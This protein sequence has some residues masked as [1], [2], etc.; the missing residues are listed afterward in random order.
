MAAEIPLQVFPDGNDGPVRM[1]EECTDEQLR[2]ALKHEYPSSWRSRGIRAELR[3][4]KRASVPRLV[5]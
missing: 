5:K 4:R 2:Q 3:A 1:T